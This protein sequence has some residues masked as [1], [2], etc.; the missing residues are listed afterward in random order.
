MELEFDR[1]T[2]KQTSK[3]LKYS[4]SFNAILSTSMLVKS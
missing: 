2:N 4:V 1:S 3:M